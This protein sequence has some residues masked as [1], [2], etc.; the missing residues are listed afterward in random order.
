MDDMRWKE[1][2]PETSMF[3]EVRGSFLEGCR[4]GGSVTNPRSCF[5][6]DVRQHLDNCL[7]LG[8]R[9][10]A[11]RLVSTSRT[12]ALLSKPLEIMEALL[13]YG[14]SSIAQSYLC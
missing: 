6:D 14:E 4:L 13:R 2:S 7:P 1:F 10:R 11:R 8:A 3:F 5:D 12:G 9:A